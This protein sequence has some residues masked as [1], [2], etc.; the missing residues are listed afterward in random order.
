LGV[1]GVGVDLRGNILC[2][3]CNTIKNIYY[4]L[5]VGISIVFE[6]FSNFSFLGGLTSGAISNVLPVT[7]GTRIYMA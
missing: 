7:Q 1:R 4:G 5:G 6:I 2:I 3:A